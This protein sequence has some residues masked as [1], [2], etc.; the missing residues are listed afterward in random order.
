MRKLV[1]LCAL[2]CS[3]AFAMLNANTS[4]S[5]DAVH[6]EAHAVDVNGTIAPGAVQGT[7]QPGAISGTASAT[8]Q[9]G[10][11]QQPVFKVE[12]PVSVASGAVSPGLVAPG[13]FQVTVQPKGFSLNIE[14][15]AIAEGAVRV[16]I[17]ASLLG[18][19]LSKPLQDAQNTVKEIYD[20]RQ[21]YEIVGGG[22]IVALIGLCWFIHVRGKG[23]IIAHLQ[24]QIA[25]TP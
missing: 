14:Q 1:L 2:L 11:F 25:K 18:D 5:P 4:V 7:I 6:V 10:A 16:N 19:K 3:P 17:D 8:I 9:T 22:V 20:S 12:S 24:R 15:G 13:A 21:T 23:Q